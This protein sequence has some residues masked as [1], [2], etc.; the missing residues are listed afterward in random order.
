M[1][2][3]FC[4]LSPKLTQ[5][6]TSGITKD[7]MI[8][9]LP[10][11]QLC[12]IMPY[13]VSVS[14]IIPVY[15]PE[16]GWELVVSDHFSELRNRLSD[17]YDINLVIVDDG[18]GSILDPAIDL[19]KRRA[20]DTTLIR[21]KDNRG[22]GYALRK[23][24]AQADGDIIVYT[25]EDFP[26]GNDVIADMIHTINEHE[27]LV[28]TGHRSKA[29]YRQLNCK[30]RWI[31]R[32]LQS[33]NAVILGLH[34]TDTQCGLKAFSSDWKA[35][36]MQTTSDGYLADVEF[37]RMLQHKKADIK[38]V[39]VQLRDNIKLGHIS[40]IKLVEELKAFFNLWLSA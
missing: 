2:F 22:K 3:L 17:V 33:M 5:V 34:I 39:K 24:M 29:Y 11:C 38:T 26:Y 37:I 10:L 1:F 14:L 15:R 12:I 19:L 8:F 23:G 13:R 21:I 18:N 6:Y 30:R 20:P 27:S 4:R 9:W 35:V 36:F 32:I 28:L 25:D 40:G 7:N 31:S 16:P